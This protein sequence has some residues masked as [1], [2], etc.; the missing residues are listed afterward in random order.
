MN[1]TTNT[2]RSSATSQVCIT[3]PRESV[4]HHTAEVKQRAQKPVPKKHLATVTSAQVKR[5]D[6]TPQSSGAKRRN[7]AQPI[8][9]ELAPVLDGTGTPV[10]GGAIT[11][12]NGLYT[13][14]C[15]GIGPAQIDE[16]QELIELYAI[17]NRLSADARDRLCA[18]ARNQALITV[19]DTIRWFQ[20]EIDAAIDRNAMKPLQGIACR[21]R[22]SR[23]R[24]IW[25]GLD[26]DPP[27]FNALRINSSLLPSA[28]D[29][30]AVEG[31]YVMVLF[32]GSTTKYG[33]LQQLC[34]SLYQAQ[35]VCLQAVDLDAGKIAYL[36]LSGAVGFSRSMPQKNAA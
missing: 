18:A 10:D 29:C 23:D 13:L 20:R 3:A 36:K 27:K 22:K 4:I 11:F 34:W 25:L 7:V 28:E 33:R 19:P 35:P 12:C 14:Y 8:Q 2:I 9:L 31:L 24:T 6:S 15:C 21:C 1:S 17:A 16:L 32:E 5:G 30:R 26:F